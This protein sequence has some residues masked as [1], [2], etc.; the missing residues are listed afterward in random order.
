MARRLGGKIISGE[1]VS[2]GGKIKLNQLNPSLDAYAA[3]LENLDVELLFP[4]RDILEGDAITELLGW[5]W[6]EG[7]EHPACMYSGNYRKMNGATVYSDE[8]LRTFLTEF[9]VPVSIRL[10]KILIENPNASLQELQ[11]PLWKWEASQ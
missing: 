5:E 3:V 11:K 7:K 2:H 1:R 10:G 9:L 6:E 4:I 8:G